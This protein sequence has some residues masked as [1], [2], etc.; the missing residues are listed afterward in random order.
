MHVDIR[1]TESAIRLSRNGSKAARLPDDDLEIV[2]LS[3]AR[4]R[5]MDEAG[6]AIA[7]QLNGPLTALLLYMGEI[8]QHSQQLS[9]SAGNRV[10]LQKVVENALQQTER[11]CAMM[12]QIAEIARRSRP[13]RQAARPDGRQRAGRGKEGLAR[14]ASCLRRRRSEAADQAR[15]RGPEPDQRGLLQQAG[16]PAHADQP[17]GPSKAIAPRRC[18]SSARETPRTLS[19]PALLH[20]M[21]CSRYLRAAPSASQHGATRCLA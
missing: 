3:A 19:A 4:T 14:P 21:Q 18:E 10:Y 17:R 7:R 13:L 12:K 1:K 8:K 20:P 9:Q 5:A 2:R 11:V 15:A 16:R 6:A